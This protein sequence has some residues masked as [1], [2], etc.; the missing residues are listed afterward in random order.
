MASVKDQV[1]CSGDTPMNL[2]FPCSQEEAVTC[3]L[4]HGF[5][6]VMP[7]KV[8]TDVVIGITCVGKLKLDSLWIGLGVGMH[9]CYLHSTKLLQCLVLRSP[10]FSLS[11]MFSQDMI[12]FLNSVP[13]SRGLH[14]LHGQTTQLQLILCC[15]CNWT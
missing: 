4:L 15:N 13:R 11:F 7:R 9:F 2:V 5:Q 6:T 14:M 10:E 1:V 8:N 3:I 12:T